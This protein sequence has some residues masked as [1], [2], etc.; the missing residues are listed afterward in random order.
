MDDEITELV[1]M[2]ADDGV[3]GVGSPANGMR[4]VLIKSLDN[5]ETDE[6]LAKELLE[7][8]DFIKA[9]YSMADKKKM[10]GQGKAILNDA[11]KPSYPIDDEDDL[12]KAIKAVG[13]GGADHDSI[14]KFVIKRAKALGKADL[15][16]S[17]W[18]KNGTLKK[19]K[20]GKAEGDGDD[21]PIDAIP[22]YFSADG[23][24]DANPG[25]S[26]WEY[27]DA[28]T[29]I[30]AG[31]M[32]SNASAIVEMA[33][34]REQAEVDAG[35]DEDMEGVWSLQDAIYS[36]QYALKTVAAMA[37]GEETES[38]MAALDE[39][40]VAKSLVAQASGETPTT[41]APSAD[42][43]KE[44]LVMDITQE[45]L[46]EQVSAAVAK[47]LAD[48]EAE[49]VTKAE[50]EAKAL[51]EARALVAKADAEAAASENK[52]DEVVKEEANYEGVAPELVELISKS[53][54]DATAPLLAKNA[55]LEE[56]LAKGLGQPAP[57]NT[58]LSSQ[59]MPT[60][61][62]RGGSL[63]KTP[64]EA[65]KGEIAKADAAGD[66]VKSTKARQEL[67]AGILRQAYAGRG[68][69]DSDNRSQRSAV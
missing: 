8:D 66:V 27:K 50:A 44:T 34:C 37:F 59:S 19:T 11:G 46:D 12:K 2:D 43:G 4:F 21:S 45:Q 5:S 51:E 64:F 26:A 58:L 68:Y 23:N 65:I 32:L 53:V 17:N 49:R 22:S 61:G 62:P 24:P 54:T 6:D 67:A 63:D 13:R 3:H 39:S 47:A 10:V 30:A 33:S 9:K 69:D 1:Q 57:T 28:Q 14:R 7:Y 38:R 41:G 20:V 48:A 36:I 42:N 29:L 55:E 60:E 40:D 56:R 31:Q 15:I 18:N 35:H 52:T 16:P 25:D